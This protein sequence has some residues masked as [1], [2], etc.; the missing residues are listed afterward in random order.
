MVQDPFWIKT[1]FIH[2]ESAGWWMN[3]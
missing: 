1:L 3:L 2:L